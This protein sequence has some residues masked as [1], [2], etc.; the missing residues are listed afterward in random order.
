MTLQFQ[1]LPE[2]WLRRR[3][4]LGVWEG[5]GKVAAVGV[6]CSPPA[7]PL[8]SVRGGSLYRSFSSEH[9]YYY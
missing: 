3:E 1:T 2:E 5:K 6:A 7:R 9:L 8:P 4:G